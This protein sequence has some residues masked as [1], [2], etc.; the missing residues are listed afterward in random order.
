MEMDIFTGEEIL[1]FMLGTLSALMSVGLIYSRK[2]LR[3]NW[4]VMALT[5]LG[6]FLMLFC[7]AWFIS[8]ILEGEPQAAN[9]GLLI[10]GAP[11]LIIIGVVHRMIKRVAKAT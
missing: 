10:F 8:S 1:F 9:M 11:V 5:S 6:A 7:F 2:R 3:L 4:L